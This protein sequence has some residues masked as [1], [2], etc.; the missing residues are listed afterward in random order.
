VEAPVAADVQRR[1]DAALTAMRAGRDK[2]AMTA[3]QGMVRDNGDLSGPSANLG[4]LYYRAG[5]LAEAQ[6]ALEHAIA[7]NPA[8]PAYHNQL[9]IVLRANGKFS[10]ARKAYDK[11]LA[12]DP[13]YADAHLN[14]GILYD[15][16]LI[17]LPK[18][19][20]HYERYQ[21]LHA[22]ED[23]QVAKWIVDLKQRM[24]AAD[25]NA[26]KEKG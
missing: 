13:N 18:A 16:Y 11:A 7:I 8:R 24:Q 15:L 21:Q 6:K 12:L 22:G 5:N 9:G 20:Q 14:L 10:E 17:E 19:L 25:R 23:K 26:K 4:I 3:L 2:E 1:Y